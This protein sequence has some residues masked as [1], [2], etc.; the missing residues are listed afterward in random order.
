[1]KSKEDNT[2]DEGLFTPPS[3]LLFACGA[4][5]VCDFGRK[6]GGGGGDENVDS[7][8][9][10]TNS[11]SQSHRGIRTFRRRLEEKREEED[12]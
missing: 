12:F 11:S 3:C 2:D 8:V 1:M 4:L 7:V 5:V 9:G 10:V 6:E